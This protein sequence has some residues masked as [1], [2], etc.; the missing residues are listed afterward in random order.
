AEAMPK[1]GGISL[2]TQ[3]CYV[4]MPISGFDKV[5]EGDY[6]LL[7]VDDSGIGI[8]AE[9]LDRIFE[10]FYTKKVM[11]RSGT[12]LGMAVVWGTVKDHKG[13]IDVQSTEGKGTRFSLY[14]PVTRKLRERK[15]TFTDN[16]RLTALRGNGEKILIVDD[17]AE[18]REITTWMLTKL[19]YTVCDV[20]SGEAALEYLTD[21]K[22][23]LLILDMIMEPGLDGL[24]TYRRIVE[25]FPH[26]KAVIVSGYSESDRVKKMQ[27]LG[28]GTYV[29]KPFVMEDIGRAV[30]IELGRR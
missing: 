2:S 25:W 7:S 28:A 24:D 5:A 12:G 10:P 8:A 4:D 29:K 13:Y 1:G 22:V 17:V 14:F 15:E 3:N 11:G 19:G 21:H 26:Q 27:A 18:Q 6:V 23:D 30:K 20:D 16:E 9:D